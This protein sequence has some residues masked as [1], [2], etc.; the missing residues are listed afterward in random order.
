MKTLKFLAIVVL[1]AAIAMFI[2]VGVLALTGSGKAFAAISIFGALLIAL[3][4]GAFDVPYKQS[5]Y[6]TIRHKAGSRSRTYGHAAIFLGT[7]CLFI[8][9]QKECDA[10]ADDL[11]HWGQQVDVRTLTGEETFEI[12]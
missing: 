12:L 9:T 10:R 3:L 6:D 7:A 8:G 11:W 1:S 2:G 4:L 5:K